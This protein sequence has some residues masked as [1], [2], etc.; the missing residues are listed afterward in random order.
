MEEPVSPDP[1]T[2][3]LVGTQVALSTPAAPPDNTASSM[4]VCRRDGS[5][6]PVDV[7]KIVRAV[8]RCCA[9]LESVDALRVATRTISG[10][11]DGAT[12][13]ELDELS[14]HTAASLMAEEPE[15]SKLAA[16]LLTTYIDEEVAGLGVH[17]FSQSIYLGAERGLIADSVAEMVAR[18]SRKLDDA[19]DATQ[20]NR[21][22][23][24]GIRIIYDRYLL[25]D[26]ASRSVIATAQHFFLRVACGL[27]RS[28][29]E[30]IQF[31]RLISSLKYRPSSPTL[32]NS[33]TRHMQMSSCYLLDSPQDDLAAIYRRYGDVAALSKFAGVEGLFFYAA[34]AY[35][36]FLRSK[37]LLNG[38][39]TGTDWVFRDE[40]AHMRFAF[41]VVDL[42][43]LEE[44]DL[45][46]AAAEDRIVQM[47]D[48]AVNVEMRFAEDLL[49]GGVTGLSMRD[50]RRH[51]E[52]VADQRLA[53]LS[54]PPRYKSKNPFG[55]MELQDVQELA[56]SSSAG[57]RRTKTL[58][59]VLSPL[60]RRFRNE[61]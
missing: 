31:Y 5:S 6:E 60:T 59:V 44:P 2:L 61:P 28:P 22:E 15:Y 24:F 34:F 41:A 21:F 36:Y 14:I 52:Y 50:M 46:D 45:I 18:H 29:S 54:L 9:G 3:D 39:A 33:G 37:G 38:L 27:S 20:S 7:N 16:R 55:F 23:Y 11:H 1:T 48:D 8:S 42:A 10:L 51:L 13:R 26:P 58:L 19:G 49:S 57:S 35:V 12:T 40:S 4:Q 56:N 47:L 25:R 32:F 30:A 53:N 43:R 17:S